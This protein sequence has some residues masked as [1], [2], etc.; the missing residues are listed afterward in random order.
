MIHD[1]VL[2]R[3]LIYTL[4]QKP[5]TRNDIIILGGVGEWEHKPYQLLLEIPWLIYYVLERHTCS[6]EHRR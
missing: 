5:K 3:T 4:T 2:P 6:L 1:P